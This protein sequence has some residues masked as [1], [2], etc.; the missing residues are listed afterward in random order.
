M[1]QSALLPDPVTFLELRREQ[2]IP[3]TL[4]TH[5]PLFVLVITCNQ[6]ADVV[7]LGDI[8][9]NA[10]FGVFALPCILNRYGYAVAASNYRL[11]QSATE[12]VCLTLLRNS[13][14]STVPQKCL[15]DANYV[16][17]AYV[18]LCNLRMADSAQQQQI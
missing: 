2:P 15:L 9:A 17:I 14:I 4:L 3:H 16:S 5:L 7:S 10:T 18:S 13:R 11:I 12:I 1:V 8:A 6:V